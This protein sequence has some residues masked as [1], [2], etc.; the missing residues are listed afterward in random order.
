MDILCQYIVFVSWIAK[1]RLF[2]CLAEWGATSI[3]YL[4][5]YS[6]GRLGALQTVTVH[7]WGRIFRLVCHSMC[8]RLVLDHSNQ[9]WLDL[10][11]SNWTLDFTAGQRHCMD[12]IN[13]FKHTHTHTHTNQS[14]GWRYEGTLWNLGNLVKFA[15]PNT[16][17]PVQ[18][19]YFPCSQVS[20][21]HYATNM[22]RGGG[23]PANQTNIGHS[24]A[25]DSIP[26][27]WTWSTNQRGP[28]VA[29][30]VHGKT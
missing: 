17:M 28:V 5:Q 16:N 1:V 4:Y 14:Q 3:K 10:L 30:L 13:F 26:K 23:G 20:K 21:H 19:V 27:S 8:V 12:R 18:Q 25:L 2:V 29:N 7:V 9:K 11:L 15:L 6:L 22:L 24:C